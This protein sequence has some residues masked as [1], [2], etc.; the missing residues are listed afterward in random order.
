M[1]IKKKKL[2]IYSQCFIYGG[3]ERLMKSIYDNIYISNFFNITFSYGYFKDY[4]RGLEIDNSAVGTNAA[5]APVYLLDNGNLFYKIDLA[6]RIKFFRYLFKLPFYILMKV[7]VYA[8][9]NYIYLFF[10]IKAQKPD[11]VH[12]NN[13]G[14]PAAKT[15]N[16]LARLLYFFKK[17]KVIYQI[18][19]KAILRKSII[20]VVLDNLVE[21]SVSYFITHSK[22]NAIAL[23]I[24]GFPEEKIVSF[25]SYY[26]DSNVGNLPSDTYKELK[27]SDDSIIMVSVGFLTYRKGHLFLIKALQQIKN[28]N[29]SIY[30][31]LKLLIIGDGED[32]P[33]L[34]DYIKNNNLNDSV[35]LLGYKSDY[36]SYLKVCD[37]FIIPSVEKEDLPLVLLTAMKYKKCIIASSFAGISELLSNR[38]DAVLIEPNKETL[39]RQLVEAISELAAN[40][41]L[42]TELSNHVEVTFNDKLGKEKYSNELLKLYNN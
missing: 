38:Y 3:S 26:E 1:K 36:I 30:S 12:I 15:C 2:L 35:T 8:L 39:S 20:D 42:R 4:K 31:K 28:Q 34:Q 6:I 32:K 18:N 16:Q 29:S 7:G 37:M 24:R 5:I 9:W 14:Y 10:F 25:F 17:I 23:S 19:G 22:Q 40:E 41:A 27:I 21:K 13:G 11:V 33:Q